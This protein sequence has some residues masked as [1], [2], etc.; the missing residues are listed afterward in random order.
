MIRIRDP[1]ILKRYRRLARRLRADSR[2]LWLI[3]REF[4]SVLFVLIAGMI[5]GSF[6]YRHILITGGQY[7]AFG[8]V[9]YAVIM[10]LA[11][12]G[13]DK[14]PDGA[15]FQAFYITMTLAGFYII[16]RGLS[17]LNTILFSRNFRRGEW[18]VALA[19]LYH[20]HIVVVGL[21]HVGIR[22]LRYLNRYDYDVVA[23][24]LNEDEESVDEARQ[25][26]DIPIIIGDAR[27]RETLQQ[28]N[29]SDAS[30]LIICTSQDLSNIEIAMSA[31]K[32]SRTVRIVM[33]I[34]DDEFAE[35]FRDQLNLYEVHSTSALAAPIFAG[36]ATDLAIPLNFEIDD[37]NYVL[38]RLTVHRGSLLAGMTIADMEN[39]F[40]ADVVLHQ[41]GSEAHVHP[42]GTNRAQPGDEIVIFAASE[43]VE[44]LNTFN[45]R[46]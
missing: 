39:R 34:W 31:R 21:G 12:N 43:M 24:E 19:S 9:I 18:E 23:V 29:L 22:V 8:K 11:L 5:G 26:L 3:A 28:A 40:Q 7:P 1:A 14:L 25:K 42:E 6:W 38:A 10:A 45:R 20:H 13:P 35:D 36:A 41:N 4:R 30:A 16:G 33:R 27:R 17:E 46:Q 32:L 44:M 2:R 37:E 15:A